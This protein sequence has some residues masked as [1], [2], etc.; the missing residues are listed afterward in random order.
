MKH[1]ENNFKNIKNNFQICLEYFLFSRA[2]NNFWKH[3][4]HTLNSQTKFCSQFTIFEQNMKIKWE[5]N[6]HYHS[7]TATN[8][9]HIIS[10]IFTTQ[11][12]KKRLNFQ[13]SPYYYYSLKVA[14]LIY[15]I[16]TNVF[17]FIYSFCK[18]KVATRTGSHCPGTH[19]LE[20]ST[21][22]ADH[23]N[24]CGSHSASP[25]PLSPQAP[26]RKPCSATHP[27]TSASSRFSVSRNR[28]AAGCRRPKTLPGN[29]FCSTTGSDYL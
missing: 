28:I 6:S 8:K 5:A 10:D 12:K 23:T 2:K 13:T 24:G 29:R 11:K 20:T 15:S 22:E 16:S 7:I 25:T 4:P 18:P 3:S 14:S 17:I 26:S 9:Q 1:T 19:S 27:S 21:E